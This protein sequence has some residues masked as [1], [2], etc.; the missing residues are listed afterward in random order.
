MKVL[1]IKNRLAKTPLNKPFCSTTVQNNKGQDIELAD[2]NFTRGL[3]LLMNQYAVKGGAAAHWGGPA[4]LAEIM[5]ATH[6]LMFS[7]SKQNNNE[8]YQ[9]FNFVNDAGH[10]ENGIYALR[11]NWGFDDL[12]LESLKKFRSIESKLTGHGEAHL[13]P[14]GVY[15][16]NGPLGSGLPQAQ[17]L[18][19]ADKILGNKRKTICVISDGA[20][21][22]GEAKES[23]SAIPGLYQKKKIN[24]FL[25]IISDNNTKLSGRI[26]EDSYSMKETFES[27]H[28]LGWDVV[29]V[30]EGNDLQKVY[31]AIEKSLESLN[32]S[33]R[34]ICLWCKTIKGYG[35]EDTQKA[36]SGGHGHP[37]AYG[38]DKLNDYLNEIFKGEVPPPL[39]EWAIDLQQKTESKKPGIKKEKVQIGIAAALN[40]A[41]SEGYPVFSLSSDLQGSTGLKEMHKQNPDKYI[42]L[43]VSESNMI[44]SSIG[45]AKAGLIPVVDTFAQFA[46]T[47]GNLPTIMSSLSQGPYIGIFSHTGFQDAADGASHQATTYF[48]AMSSIPDTDVYNLSTSEEAE[49]FVYE[50]IKKYSESVAS[51]E[52]PPT[53]LFFLGRENFVPKYQNQNFEI[54]K[55][56]VL[57]S[58]NQ[59]TL[60][61]SGP[62]V[63]NALEA[64]ELLKNNHNIEITVINSPQINKP[65]TNTITHCLKQTSGKLIT[66]EDHQIIGGQGQIL[67]HKLLLEGA[68]FKL[69]S[70]GINGNFG[71]SAYKALDLYKLNKLSTQDIINE[72]L[73]FN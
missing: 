23:F 52:T 67:A 60:V 62:L 57:T 65:D 44:N 69:R 56:Q 54:N 28:L 20:A 8:W 72:V 22:E 41:I 12:T 50:V 30:D 3:V 35:I 17:G 13:N 16:S 29:K 33:N 27:L 49:F 4:A 21:M 18:A 71:R 66:L 38:D 53:S 47:K 48:A 68:T 10:T 11:A 39:K 1:P 24:P 40:K 34:P 37:L 31:L 9:S 73:N 26:S 64:Y 19:I 32:N 6:S 43:G 46:I 61:T 5:S 36:A 2:P 15:I 7:I 42:D 70:M 51:G 63:Q 14:E 45:L 58:G 59:V 55:A 25:M